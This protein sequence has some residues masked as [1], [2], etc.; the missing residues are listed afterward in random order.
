ML[1]CSDAILHDVADMIPDTVV[2]IDLSNT[3]LRNIK[4]DGFSNCTNVKKLDLADNQ[5]SRLRNVMLR[6]MPNLEIFVLDRNWGISY[7]VWS[8]PDD[9]FAGLPHLKSVSI[10][11]IMLVFP[12]SFDEYAF[13]FQ[14]LPQTL[15]ELNVSI[16]GG[17]NI[18]LPLSKFTKL[19]KLG[20]QGISGTFNTITNDT[21]KSLVNIT[22]EELTI[23]A[24]NLTSVEPL[25]FYHF[26]ELKSLNINGFLCL[27]VAD[28]F[29]ALIGLQHT[30]L[31]KLHLSSFNIDDKVTLVLPE[32]VILNETFCGNL[33]L[34]F[35]TDL[36]LDQSRLVG[37]RGSK[38]C[39]SKLPKFTVLNLQFN[40]LSVFA[41]EELL[42]HLMIN[43][44]EINLSHQCDLMF[45]RSDVVFSPPIN[46]TTLD[47]SS[48]I[49][50]I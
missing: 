38:N 48:H 47:L 45:V 30:K 3:H 50:I 44:I 7:D 17:E 22:I 42:L 23:V 37:V 25:S 24:F 21:F 43:L 14:R 6:S 11:K 29:P 13:V 46:L 16:P 49:A 40:C 18:S 26:S 19:R 27:S 39:F 34:P 10:W 4:H 36:H 1:D 12:M 31:E 2:A 35:L 32:M 8:F 33:N 28:F 41:I 15:E 20:M 5:I 9:T